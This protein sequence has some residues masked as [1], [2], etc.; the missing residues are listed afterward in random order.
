MDIITIPFEETLYIQV[1]NEP[2]K[3][4]AF[5][6]NEPGNIKFGVDAPRNIK[7]NR[8]EIYLAVQQKQREEM[9]S[10]TLSLDQT[11]ASC[12]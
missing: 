12:D 10:L 1:N 7:V 11:D 2:I 6:T 4:V 5:K 8:E 9:T 3:L